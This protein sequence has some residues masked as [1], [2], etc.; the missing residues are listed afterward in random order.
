[1]A[2][3]PITRRSR[4]T[5]TAACARATCCAAFSRAWCSAVSPRAWL[6]PTGLRSAATSAPARLGGTLLER[7]GKMLA[8]AHLR[9]VR[10]G[11]R[12]R[13]RWRGASALMFGRDAVTLDFKNR[14]ES[15]LGP[16]L[17][18]RQFL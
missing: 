9:K 16:F 10:L 3:F 18:G 8:R 2:G 12:R 11:G 5:D 14:R 4:R 13:S 15:G 7:V 6:A 1:M 17:A